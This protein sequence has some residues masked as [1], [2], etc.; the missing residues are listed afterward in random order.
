MKQFSGDPEQPRL[1]PQEP[2]LITAA[3]IRAARAY[4]KLPL[5]RVAKLASI[6]RSTLG[7]AEQGRDVTT[8]TIAKIVGAYYSQG[9]EF[10]HGPWPDKPNE[11]PAS[12]AGI[13]DFLPVIHRRERR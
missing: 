2:P 3:Q 4:L 6:G 5:A 10:V 1:P 9:V 13:R 8:R 11:T 12:G 7:R